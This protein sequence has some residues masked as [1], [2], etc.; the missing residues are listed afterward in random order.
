MSWVAPFALI[1]ALLV[2]LPIL[3]HMMGRGR[4]TV[5]RFPTLRFLESS[6]LMPVRRT[7]LQDIP[8]LVLRALA[9][10]AAAMALAQP[11]FRDATPPATAD[12]R[13]ARVIVID[14]SASMQR[15]AVDL[16][17]LADSAGAKGAARSVTLR[18]ADLPA[19]LQGA[20]SWAATQSGRV[21]LVIISDFQRG[22]LTDEA[23]AAVPGEVG[24]QLRRMPVSRG[25]EGLFS[26]ARQGGADVLA[27]IA[28]VGDRTDVEWTLRPSTGL[29]SAVQ[30][31]I[32]SAAA[33]LVDATRQGAAAVGI[34]FWTDSA[35]R[36][37][38]VKTAIAIAFPGD[39]SRAAIRTGA[40]P[41]TSRRQAG[42]I[43]RLLSDP[44]IAALGDESPFDR[45]VS[46]VEAGTPLLTIVSR[47]AVGTAESA[48]LV[49]A[50]ERAAST[51]PPPSELDAELIPDATLAKW[52]RAPSARP[53]L[54]SEHVGDAPAFD[55]RWFWIIALLLLG[56]ETLLRR[57]PQYAK[58]AA[59]LDGANDVA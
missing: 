12:S 6:R 19:A 56:A 4:T 34:P 36:V 8:L 43:A 38:A 35:Q 13:V 26:R 20:A 51:V 10:V 24:I 11:L 54:Q 31:R 57:A 44:L 16:P 52:E 29:P 47:G 30:L 28:F 45:A 40:H 32:G 58:G 15:V 50:V 49:A 53:E 22:A 3:I 18:A 23:V 2:A 42:I 59:A 27:H 17:T 7:R 41:L 55:G 33:N 46:S 1:G 9:I 21:E 48:A 37:G 25:E 39:Q 14:T 5:M